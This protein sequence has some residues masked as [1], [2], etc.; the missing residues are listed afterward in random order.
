[1]KTKHWILI[2]VLALALS[3]GLGLWLLRPKAP[4]KTV[5]VVQD[6]VVTQVLDLGKDQ[7]LEL[8]GANGGTNTVEVKDGKVAVTHASCPDHICMAMGWCDSGLPIACLPNGL[9]LSFPSRD[10]TDGCGFPVFTACKMITNRLQS[11][12]PR[13][14]ESKQGGW[15]DAF[16]FLLYL[17]D[18]LPDR[19]LWLLKID[20]SRPGFPGRFFAVLIVNRQKYLVDKQR[21][22]W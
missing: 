22:P 19:R 11:F 7:I 3:L 6:G 8:T 18:S 17:A 9:I 13:E 21:K 15:K 16:S 12:C 4:E 20:L 2:L 1:M 10:G 14:T 5:T